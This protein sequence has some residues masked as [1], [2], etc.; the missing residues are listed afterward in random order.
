MHC[1]EVQH[2]IRLAFLEFRYQVVIV[3]LM[4]AMTFLDRDASKDREHRLR[5]LRYEDIR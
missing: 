2:I 4:F 3:P 5:I 1:N